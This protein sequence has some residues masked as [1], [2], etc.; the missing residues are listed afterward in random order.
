[1]GQEIA[2]LVHDVDQQIAVRY[3]DMH[4]QPENEDGAHHILQILLKHLV[5]IVFGDQ[6]ALPV[7][8]GCAPAPTI[9]SPVVVASCP[10]P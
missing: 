7:R 9:A 2:R 8:E 10:R 6:L 5:A 1:M 3:A 4:M